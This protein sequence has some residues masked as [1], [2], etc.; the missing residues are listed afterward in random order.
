M[1]KQAVRRR[2]NQA[3]SQ[4]RFISAG[5]NAQDCSIIDVGG[6]G[7]AGIS[8]K[9]DLFRFGEATPEA[10][11]SF[12]PNATNWSCQ[13]F[14][15][16]MQSDYLIEA[17]QGGDTETAEVGPCSG[18]GGLEIEDPIEVPFPNPGGLQTAAGKK[19]V[20]LKGKGPA[21]KKV[22]VELLELEKQ[23]GQF[24]KVIG[25]HFAI[26]TCSNAAAGK[27]WNH[28]DF[29]VPDTTKEFLIRLR[30]SHFMVWRRHTST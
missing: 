12:V 1:G 13:F 9:V 25:R 30:W 27:M 28:D 8:V 15:T 21:G 20:K 17:T 23:D 2:A 29:E 7:V 14:G 24:F 6:E 22:I 3:T 18:P 11:K 16:S 4:M 5:R 10:S 26:P 19:K